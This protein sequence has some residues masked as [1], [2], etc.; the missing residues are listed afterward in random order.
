MRTLHFSG[1]MVV[2]CLVGVG[3]GSDENGSGGGGGGSAATGG[4]G[5][6]ADAGGGSGESAEGSAG[7]GGSGEAGSTNSGGSGG[8]ETTGGTGGEAGAP[9]TTAGSG[10]VVET[11]G[12][13]G[14]AAGAPLTTAGTGGAA[15][16][17]V[18]S[19]GSGGGGSGGH[20][21]GGTVGSGGD[22]AGRSGG[23]GAE[24]SGGDGGEESV[25][26]GSPLDCEN[27]EEDECGPAPA[28]V[29]EA[30]SCTGTYFSC[31]GECL[32]ERTQED[33]DCDWDASNGVCNPNC[34]QRWCENYFTEEDCNTDFEC[35]W[36]GSACSNAA[37][38]CEEEWD[39]APLS[40]AACKAPDGSDFRNGCTWVASCADSP[41]T[42][43]ACE[44]LTAD[45]C[46]SQP[47]CRRPGVLGAS[48][49]SIVCTAAA[50]REP[51]LPTCQGGPAIGTEA[52]MYCTARCMSDADCLSAQTPMSCLTTCPNL[53]ESLLG[54]CVDDATHA[55]L[56]A[57]VCN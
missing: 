10:G 14:G 38:E 26:I 54:Y 43:V 9:L 40:E 15:G 33:C 23:G 5:G 56:L 41:T 6:S 24:A 46:W 3:C 27:I 31:C 17:P 39:C 4:T 28:C 34:A 53:D 48:V 36:D 13:G 19:A 57:D 16:A 7:S 21:T 55:W 50:C 37:N 44:S 47:G 22:T 2:A 42:T 8:S 20:D 52:G 30:G 18:T 45:E 35:V 12:G 29:P 1:L 32:L 11:P 51:S 25:C 49:P